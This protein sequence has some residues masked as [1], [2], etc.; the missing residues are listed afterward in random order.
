MI[1]AGNEG[2][3]GLESPSCISTSISVGSTDNADVVQPF[4]NRSSLMTFFAPGL[5]IETSSSSPAGSFAVVSGTSPST[6]NVAGAWAVL[7]QRSPA[8]T[9]TAIETRPPDHGCADFHKRVRDS[10]D[11]RRGGSRG[12]RADRAA[13]R[14][15]AQGSRRRRHT[16]LP[17]SLVAVNNP[18]TE[19]RQ[20]A[21]ATIVMTFNKAITAATATVTEG[22]ATAA[23]PSFSGNDVIVGLTGVSNAQ[24]VTVSLTGVAAADGT[25]GGSGS[26][27][28]GFLLGDVN[29][30]RVISIADLG[31]VNQQ[32]SQLVTSANYLKDVN[33]SGTLSVADKGIANANL[34]RSLPAP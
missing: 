15:V 19:P 28:I 24:Y 11:Q 34:T 20:S 3:V 33:A 32:L 1:S 27:R 14:G 13:E 2:L 5:N 30:N 9:V 10:A 6:A 25:S 18:S 4:S 29:Q 7:K 8:A 21:T 31:L 16:D 17:L 26:V 12:A 23:A 22:V